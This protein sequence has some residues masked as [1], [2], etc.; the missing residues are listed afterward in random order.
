[1]IQRT[2]VAVLRRPR[3]VTWRPKQ[4]WPGNTTN[5][6]SDGGVGGR[7]GAV[8]PA[9]LLLISGR[10]YRLAARPYGPDGK[11]EETLTTRE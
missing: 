2:V 1:M 9:S 6:A 7:S 3:M 10:S 5:R 4:G 11:E 8:R